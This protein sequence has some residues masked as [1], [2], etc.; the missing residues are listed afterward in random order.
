M[1]LVSALCL[2]T[3]VPAGGQAVEYAPL[4]A[5]GP[6]LGVPAAELDA[7]LACSGPLAG[8]ERNPI[9][10]VPGTNLDPGPN[11]SWNYVR[12]LAGM[13]WPHCTVTL[14]GHG[15]G[16]IQVAAEY[17]VHAVRTMSDESGRRVDIVGFSQGGMLPRWALRFWP[18]T[19]AMVG[20]LVGL[21]PSNHGTLATDYLCATS[22][23]PSYHQQASTS[24]FVAALNS[25][26]ETFA[27]IDYTVIYTH[28]DEVVT[29]NSG[30][31][32]SSSLHGGEG[33]IANVALQDICPLNV[34][35]H[36]AVGS[37]DPVAYAIAIDALTH[38]GPTSPARVSDAV[39]AELLQPGVDPAT[40][41]ADYAAYLADVARAFQESEYTTAE[42]ALACYATASCQAAP[43]TDPAAPTD[44]GE[45]APTTGPPAPAPQPELPA[46]GHDIPALALAVVAV[47]AIALRRA[48][49]RSGRTGS[50]R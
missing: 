37:Y 16:D 15:M 14:P 2:S 31:M 10:L 34:A 5:P 27:G 45:Q 36:L 26:T 9:L 42:P 28:Y 50:T 25:G 4:D 6:A 47:L 11:F 13:G 40:F 8:V 24:A 41:A 46:T 12:A 43:P 23:P 1:A 48:A 22:C 33:A 20:D 21:A 29:P 49:E 44:P 32:G 18:D 30:D 7:A 35:E 3:N 38:P 17:V 19:R 39:C